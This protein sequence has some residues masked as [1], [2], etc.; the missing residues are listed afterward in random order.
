MRIRQSFLPD[1]PHQSRK[2]KSH[3]EISESK[4]K[5][6]IHNQHYFIFKPDSPD[7]SQKSKS[8]LKSEKI[9]NVHDTN[10]T[11]NITLHSNQTRPNNKLLRRKLGNI[12]ALRTCNIEYIDDGTYFNLRTRNQ[13][14]ITRYPRSQL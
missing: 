10:L 14:P 9:Q 8:H 4:K 1:S 13:T 7:Q 12:I 11:T 3:F 5:Q 2:F 6:K